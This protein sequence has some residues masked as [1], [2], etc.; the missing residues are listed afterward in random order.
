MNNNPIISI[1]TISYNAVKDIEN[2]ILSV[3]NQTYPNIEYIIIDGGSSDGTL[4]IIKKYQDK[5]TYWV[6]EPD[7]GIYDAMN[8]G[9]LKA[10]GIWLNFM[11]AGDTF[12]N[13]QVLEEVFKDND[14]SDTDVI[15]GDT[16]Y[17]YP[18]KEQI[19]RA[20]G[21]SH[22]EVGNPFCHQSVFVRT[23]L[24][25]EYLFNITYKICADYYFFHT[26]YKRGYSFK[27]ENK[28]I[29]KYLYGGFSS[30]AIVYMLLEQWH[31][32]KKGEY[33]FLI[34]I[35]WNVFM[36]KYKKLKTKIV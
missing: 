24:Q 19:Q 13:E 10:T 22:I 27:Y 9:A 28:V 17:I 8:K 2:T 23:K 30:S 21:L 29:S 36:D 32:S 3:L 14:W 11:N 31:I 20:L 1:I 18:N 5:I 25:Q 16:I 12:Y 26:L 35:I 33:Y 4:D 6:S 7:K 34:R 15:Y